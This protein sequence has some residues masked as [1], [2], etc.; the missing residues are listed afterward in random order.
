MLLRG[1][2]ADEARARLEATDGSLDA[3][4]GGGREGE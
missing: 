1:L 3:A 4:L 2:D